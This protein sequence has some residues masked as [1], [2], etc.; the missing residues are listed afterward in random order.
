[1]NQKR[2]SSG[3]GEVVVWLLFGAGVLAW[4]GWVRPWWEEYRVLVGD[5][6]M[7]SKSGILGWGSCLAGLGG[8]GCWWWVFE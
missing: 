8:L 1:M 6:S 3:S 5:A 7:I 2:N 4:F